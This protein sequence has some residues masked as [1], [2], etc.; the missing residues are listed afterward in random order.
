MKNSEIIEFFE[1][2]APPQFSESWDNVGL[3]VGDKNADVSKVLLALDVTDEVV[4]EAIELGASLIITHHPLIFRPIK[5]VTKDNALGERIIKLIK[6]DISVFVSHTN[7]DSTIGGT[8]DILSEILKLSD[9]QV[10]EP[11]PNFENYGLGRVGNLQN[12]KTL[13]ELL[14]E[15]KATKLFDYVNYATDNFGLNKVVSKV[16]LC[17][18]SASNDL[19]FKAKDLGCDVYVT[20]DLTYHTAQIAKDIGISIIDIGHYCSENIVFESI[21]NMLKSEFTDI[22]FINSK[23]NAQTIYNF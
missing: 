6:N 10:L 3:L 18:G 19:I 23:V 21:R 8:N 13:E 2:F 14:K 4:D 11:K 17:T 1:N 12:P 7:L 15:I 5:S 20:G 16:G 9:L 22:N